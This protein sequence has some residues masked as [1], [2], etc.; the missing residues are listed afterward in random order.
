MTDET[1]N[2]ILEHLKA[3][4]DALTESIATK[5]QVDAVEQRLA[6]EIKQLRWIGGVLVAL[7]VAIL[8]R[9]Q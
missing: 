5:A 9:G 8:M 2:L 4:R 6:A 3:L 1:A 7:N